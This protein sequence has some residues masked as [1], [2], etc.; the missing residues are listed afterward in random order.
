MLNTYC[1]IIEYIC[2]KV[3]SLKIYKLKKYNYLHYYSGPLGPML[4]PTNK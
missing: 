4:L 2:A 1:I 3:D